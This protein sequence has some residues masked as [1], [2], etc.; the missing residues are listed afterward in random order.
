MPNGQHPLHHQYL[1]VQRSLQM[2]ERQRRFKGYGCVVPPTRAIFAGLGK[3]SDYLAP[4]V[5][6]EKFRSYTTLTLEVTDPSI[7]DADISAALKATG[8]ANLADGIKNIPRS[9]K[10]PCALP[11]FRLWISKAQANI[12]NSQ[13]RWTTLSAN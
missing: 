1:D 11:A 9:N 12:K 4:L 8:R 6:D 3:K 5:Q 13:K 2:D 10:T 7:K